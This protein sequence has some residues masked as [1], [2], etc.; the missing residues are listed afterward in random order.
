I[1]SNIISFNTTYN[2]IGGGLYGSNT[3][4]LVVESNRFVSNVTAITSKTIT[5]HSNISSPWSNFVISRN[6]FI[7]GG[8]NPVAIWEHGSNP[9]DI[10]EHSI[11]NNTFVTNS[12]DRLY[13][14]IFGFPG[15]ISSDLLGINILN[16]TLNINHDA[17]QASG[18]VGM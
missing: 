13:R 7:G 18:N 10:K 3:V 8:I 4:R 14:D 1:I 12:Y 5:L 2:S 6:T 9:D 15:D 16:T 11:L 17:S